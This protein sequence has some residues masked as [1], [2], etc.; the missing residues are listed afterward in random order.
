MA[1]IICI[2]MLGFT[3]L[4]KTFYKK[5]KAGE[6][7]VLN[8][9]ESKPKVIRGGALILPVVH[10]SIVLDLN[11]QVIQ[12]EKIFIDKIKA[13]YDLD[14]TSFAIQIENSDAAILTAYERINVG[15]DSMEKLKS[16][17][18][19]SLQECF[20]STKD[21]DELKKQLSQ[22]LKKVGYELVV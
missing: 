21:Y 6:V 10:R 9:L 3:I 16:V 2:S 11:T 12:L 4:F 13:L 8:A 18:E 19:H 5:A 20:I 15:A 17:L 22:S 14:L 1:S 7:I